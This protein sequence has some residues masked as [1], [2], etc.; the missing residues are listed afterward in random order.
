MKLMD[1][2]CCLLGIPPRPRNEGQEMKLTN[3]HETGCNGNT[4]LVF[5][6]AGSGINVINSCPY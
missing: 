4:R 6:F 5:R 2:V 3:V 1:E